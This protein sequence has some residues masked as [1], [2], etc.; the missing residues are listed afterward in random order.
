M[1]E[2]RGDKVNV[3]KRG[4]GISETWLVGLKRLRWISAGAR[5]RVVPGS[6][7]GAVDAL[8]LMAHPQRQAAMTD[9]RDLARQMAEKSDQDLLAMFASPDDWTAA[10]LECARAELRKRGFD[11]PGESPPLE[12]ERPHLLFGSPPETDEREDRPDIYEY[13]GTYSNKD[14]RL[15]LDAFVRGEIEYTL[16]LHKM[17]LADMSPGQ[18]AFG[19]T[20][21]TGVGVAI[22]VHTDDC[23]RAME[24][25][26]RVLKIMP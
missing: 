16:D 13:I 9:P 10:A 24:I 15:L 2:S 17:A 20:F 8:L 5:E 12:W 18:A 3:I 4:S 6:R 19:G 23:E 26:E 14:A 11:D 7:S 25:R 21:G 22:G 1:L